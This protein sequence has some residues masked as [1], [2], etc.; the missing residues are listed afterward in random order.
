MMALE[1]L[2]DPIEAGELSGSV[3]FQAAIGEETAEPATL[4]LLDEGYGGDYAVVL[5]PTGLRTATSEKGLSWYEITI[6]G[7][8]S[9]ASRPDQRN[10]AIQNARPVLDAFVEYDE[11][12]RG[13]R[14]YLV[15]SA[16][17]T[18][19]EFRAGTKENV[20]PESATITID[21]RFIPE[22]SV[23][24]VDDEVDELLA[25][26]E[27][28]HG[29]ETTWRRTQTYESAT[30]LEDNPL[31]EVF[32][33]H[34]ERIA[35]SDPSPW[36]SERRPTCATSST[37]TGSRRSPGVPERSDRPIPSTSTSISGRCLWG[38]RCWSTR[39]PNSRIQ[40]RGSGDEAFGGLLE[41][42]LRSSSKANRDRPD[43]VNSAPVNGPPDDQY[44]NGNPIPTKTAGR[45]R[46]S[47]TSCR[48]LLTRPPTVTVLNG[49]I[50]ERS[51][52]RRT[53]PRRP[54]S[55]VISH[56]RSLCQSGRK[57]LATRGDMDPACNR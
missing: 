40:K 15:G 28:E 57:V 8:P 41:G 42:D 24:E 5:E 48:P 10:N 50:Y 22:E 19:T 27:N 52:V 14:D 7:E 11:R 46:R 44:G 35:D 33:T 53:R 34:P 55:Q 37:T 54:S 38:T 31:A 49:G 21:R 1:T 9:H 12:I 2:R 29:I 43:W 51:R 32:C 36:G 16:Y 56:L 4:S 26:V 45:S 25:S 18:T 3:V 6:V 30:I 13:R 17:A 47:W 23:E 20:V 39:L